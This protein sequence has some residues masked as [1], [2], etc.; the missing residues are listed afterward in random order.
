MPELSDQ[1]KHVLALIRNSGDLAITHHN[2]SEA[3]DVLRAS[4]IL[5]Q[6]FGL[7]V[8][9][10]QFEY[11]HSSI[12]EKPPQALAAVFRDFMQSVENSKAIKKD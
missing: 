3:R 5:C 7:D 10:N 9:P 8:P 6:E 1:V 4:Y 12:S 11:V 2:F